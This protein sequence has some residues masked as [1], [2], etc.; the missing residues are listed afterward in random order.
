MCR[1]CV[2]YLNVLTFAEQQSPVPLLLG[3]QV[4]SQP[5]FC[6]A[7]KVGQSVKLGHLRDSVRG[8]VQELKAG[9]VG[10]VCKAPQ[11]VVPQV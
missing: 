1:I 11:P 3:Y 8:K 2:C 10:K 4:V 9:K 6:Q 5:D 7:D